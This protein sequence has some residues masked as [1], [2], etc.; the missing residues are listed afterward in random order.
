MKEY[1]H[2]HVCSHCSHQ[3]FL[4]RM[5]GLDFCTCSLASPGTAKNMNH[6]SITHRNPVVQSGFKSRHK[7]SAYSNCLAMF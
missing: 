6:D 2:A 1:T 5:L 4:G 7:T 3:N